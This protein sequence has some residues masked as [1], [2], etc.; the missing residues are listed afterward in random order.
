MPGRTLRTRYVCRYC[1]GGKEADLVVVFA[2]ATGFALE[3]GWVAA[4]VY[5]YCKGSLD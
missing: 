3:Q 1:Q 4:G 2:Y 5:P